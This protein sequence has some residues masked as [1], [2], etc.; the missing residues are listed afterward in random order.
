M[1]HTQTD[2]PTIWIRYLDGVFTIIR[3]D[4]VDKYIH[5]LNAIN[6]FIQFTTEIK[7]Y[8]KISL[9]DLHISREINGNLSFNVV[10]KP[11]F[12]GS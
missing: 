5:D 12:S 4:L 7:S 6:P 9:L 8:G 2:T 3:K 11:T 10:R 1:L